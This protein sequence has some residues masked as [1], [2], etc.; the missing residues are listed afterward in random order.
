MSLSGRCSPRRKEPNSP[1]FFAPR[2]FRRDRFLFEHIEN[3]LLCLDHSS[4]R[5]PSASRNRG[6]TMIIHYKTSGSGYIIFKS[7]PSSLLGSLFFSSEYPPRAFLGR[8]RKSSLS[9]KGMSALPTN[10]R[11]WPS[12]GP[13][14]QP[15]GTWPMRYRGALSEASGMSTIYM[16]SRTPIGS[17]G[18]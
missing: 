11:T 8:P 7:A 9:S 15:G 16:M 12:A 1:I 2:A 5:T 18:G 4:V 17:G 13:S 10:P 3:V 6:P 14:H